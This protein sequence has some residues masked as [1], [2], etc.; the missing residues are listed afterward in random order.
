MK[1]IILPVLITLT[2]CG[3][4]FNGTS[5]DVNFDSNVAGVDIYVDGMKVC[6]TPCSYPVD[7]HSGSVSVIAKKEGYPDQMQ[8]LKAGFSAASV[9]NLTFWPS[10][11]TDVA[12]GGMWKYNRDSVYIDMEKK[13]ADIQQLNKIK[14]DVA[15]RRFALF[16]YDNLKLEAAKGENGEYIAGL[17]GLTGKTPDELIE[18]INVANSEVSLAHALTG[19]Q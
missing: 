3:T 15:T 2:A 12:T 8:S 5:Q 19:I 14:K 7:R 9:L 16:G 13:T 11:L 4:I 6:K 17:S 18:V 10:W 1:K